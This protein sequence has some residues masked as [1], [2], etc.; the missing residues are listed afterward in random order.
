[1]RTFSLELLTLGED[2]GRT[3]SDVV[4]QEGFR[5]AN[6]ASNF[7]GTFKMHPLLEVQDN[8][9]SV[10]RP[11]TTFQLVLSV[12]FTPSTATSTI[13]C[14]F[15]SST[16]H[17]PGIFLSCAYDYQHSRCSRVA[18]AMATIS[19][20]AAVNQLQQMFT[21]FDKGTLAAVLQ[22]SIFCFLWLIADHVLCMFTT[23]IVVCF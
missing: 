3:Q 21:D 2:S 5:G 1:M 17:T 11:Q 12:P 8:Y 19:T 22:V 16:F 6:N 7:L 13:A 20:E 23:G 10:E 15:T 18:V 14:V 9:L 4:K